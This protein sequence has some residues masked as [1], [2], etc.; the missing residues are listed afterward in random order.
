MGKLTTLADCKEGDQVILK[1]ISDRELTIRLYSMGCILGELIMVE[2]IAPLGD[3]L[4]ISVEDCFISLRKDDAIKM[5][6]ANHK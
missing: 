3:P 5:E 6:V 4:I 2:R 1:N